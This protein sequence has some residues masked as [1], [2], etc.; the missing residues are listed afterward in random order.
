[1]TLYQLIDQIIVDKGLH[2]ENVPALDWRRQDGIWFASFT[3]VLASPLGQVQVTL[4]TTDPGDPA[5]LQQL[6]AELLGD[7]A[8]VRDYG[9]L[10]DVV[11]AG[12]LAQLL[13]GEA[14]FQRLVDLYDHAP[15]R[16]SRD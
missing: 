5:D 2:L 1:M 4:P 9:G 10:S 3:Y 8:Y 13:G 6:L 14:E 16:Q 11:M 15:L 7:A 12:N